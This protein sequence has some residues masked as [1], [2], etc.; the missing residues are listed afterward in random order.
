MAT[1]KE[2]KVSRELKAQARE[3]GLCDEWYGAW[4]EDSTFD[5]LIGK[6]IAGYDFCI[7][8]DW[9]DVKYVNKHFPKPV[10]RANGVFCD[11]SSAKSDCRNAVVMGRS[12]VELYYSDYTFGDVRVRHSSHVTVKVDALAIVHIHAYEHSSVVVFAEE[13]AKVTL[14][15]H[16]PSAR[17]TVNGKVKVVYGEEEVKH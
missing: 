13:G 9:P 16:S 7:E 15:V 14:F 2:K 10:L 4:D 12:S 17:T 11:D 8:H 3:L 1:S 5:E 6:F